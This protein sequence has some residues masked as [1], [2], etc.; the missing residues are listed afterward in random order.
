MGQL[1][2]GEPPVLATRD[3]ADSCRRQ[4]DLNKRK[5]IPRDDC[6]TLLGTNSR[7]Q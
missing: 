4:K 5:R 1:R 6:D 7:L 2:Q 3:C